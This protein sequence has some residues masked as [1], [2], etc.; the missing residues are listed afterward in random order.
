MRKELLILICKENRFNFKNDVL[1]AHLLYR[2][3][4]LAS[5]EV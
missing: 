4:N 5:S 2:F 3:D 1:T